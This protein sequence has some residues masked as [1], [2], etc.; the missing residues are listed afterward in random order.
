[1]TDEKSSTRSAPTA[2]AA[3]P[4]RARPSGMTM[5]DPA[6]S[7]AETRL[8]A[9]SGTWDWTLVAHITP[10]KANPQPARTPVTAVTVK[11]QPKAGAS[12][13]REKQNMAQA[14]ATSGRRGRTRM[15]SR[16]PTMVPA[17]SAEAI[18]PYPLAPC[19][20]VRRAAPSGS[21]GPKTNR[22]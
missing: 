1:M 5:I 4:A 12:G 2:S 20:S 21:A 10:Q 11:D 9:A 3:G 7:Y 17:P 16:P 8:S 19:C 22:P 15:P 14:P 13:L 18:Q 6:T